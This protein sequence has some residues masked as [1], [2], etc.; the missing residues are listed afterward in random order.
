MYDNLFIL[1]VNFIQYCMIQCLSIHYY[2]ISCCILWYYTI[3]CEMIYHDTLLCFLS[4]CLYIFTTHLFSHI[5]QKG[6]YSVSILCRNRAR[7]MFS[8]KILQL[9]TASSELT[10]LKSLRLIV[11]TQK[12]GK[13]EGF[14]D[15]TTVSIIITIVLCCA[16]TMPT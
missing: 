14:R 9:P 13:V 5:K 7:Q 1:Y 3:L 8:T 11:Y 16:C 12:N 15:C 4:V 2:K 6:L 10:T